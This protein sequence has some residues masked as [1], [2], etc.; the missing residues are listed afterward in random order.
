MIKFF[1]KYKSNLNHPLSHGD[2]LDISFYCEK[3]WFTTI[4]R[5]YGI[6]VYTILL[7]YFE[8]NED[9]SNCVKLRD[10]LFNYNSNFGTDYK[11]NL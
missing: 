11:I 5:N 3:G 2:I 9:Y 4:L 7:K 1:D 8:Y 6:Q 10:S